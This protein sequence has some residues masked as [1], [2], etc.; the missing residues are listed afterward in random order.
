MTTDAF[1]RR[2]SEYLAGDLSPEERRQVSEHL[3]TCQA[4]RTTLE[5]LRNVIS[6][7]A[8][9][10]DSG[11]ARDLWTGIAARIQ[12]ARQM[13]VRVSPF[14][15]AVSSRLSFTLP[16]LAAAGLTLM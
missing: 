5:E 2:L 8:T 12:P 10:S 7:V 3:T 13:R 4:C 6:E 11:P 14:R 16:Q 9:L 15:R 1:T